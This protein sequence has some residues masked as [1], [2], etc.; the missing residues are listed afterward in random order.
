MAG[1]ESRAYESGWA[2]YVGMV[3]SYG[4]LSYFFRE[5]RNEQ[6]IRGSFLFSK[7]KRER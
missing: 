7:N 3:L 6:R 4:T 2:S 1:G 5:G